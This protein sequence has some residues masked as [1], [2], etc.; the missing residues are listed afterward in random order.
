MKCFREVFMVQFNHELLIDERY[1]LLTF[2]CQHK[3]KIN[4]TLF[5]IP[6]PYEYFPVM[7]TL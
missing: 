1:F 3:L 4:R 2:L 6:Y 5:I 7:Q